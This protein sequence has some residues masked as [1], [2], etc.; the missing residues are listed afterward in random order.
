MAAIE[1]RLQHIEASVADIAQAST[2]AGTLAP[3]LADMPLGDQRER[4]I[5]ELCAQGW[6]NVEADGMLYLLSWYKQRGVPVSIEVPAP[7]ALTRPV[8]ENRP[9]GGG[10]DGEDRPERQMRRGV[11]NTGGTDWRHVR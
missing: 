4:V 3:Y 11:T 9:A 2:L 6:S 1:R 7:L 5:T 10:A 8:L